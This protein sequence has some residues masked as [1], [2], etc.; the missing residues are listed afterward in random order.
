MWKR[1]LVLICAVLGGLSGCD[2]KGGS[3]STVRARK[4]ETRSAAAPSEEKQ[5]FFA[6]AERWAEAS[7]DEAPRPQDYEG[8]AEGGKVQFDGDV[9]SEPGFFDGAHDAVASPVFAGGTGRSWSAPR[10]KV[11]LAR[12]MPVRLD[13]REPPA[14]DLDRNAGRTLSAFENFEKK[15]YGYAEPIISRFG[16]RARKQNGRPEKQVPYRITIHHTE[17]SLTMKEEE[18]IRNVRAIQR[19]HMVGRGEE[20]KDDF[21]DIAYHFLIDGAGRVI[22]GRHAE[23]EGSHAGG[24]NEGNIGI[25]LMGDFNK[26]KPTQAQMDSLRRL[27]SFLALQ[28]KHDPADKGFIEGHRHYTSTACPGRHLAPLLSQLR[29]DA[30]REKT[31]IVKKI[32]SDPEEFTP[33][34]ASAPSV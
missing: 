19:Y 34:L 30:E 2:E 15:M 5:A 21:E 8:L 22:E 10:Q 12:P 11:V 6:K 29:L 33:L 28:Y 13:G 23:I 26:K 14:P 24:A 20:G 3:G 27:V 7:R 18:T 31:E 32:Q 4:T 17:T 25:A 1:R 9:K 16:W